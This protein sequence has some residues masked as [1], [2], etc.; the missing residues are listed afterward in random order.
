[1]RP[2]GVAGQPPASQ[3]GAKGPQAAISKADIFKGKPEEAEPF[4][5]HQH[6]VTQRARRQLYVYPP[7]RPGPAVAVFNDTANYFWPEGND[8]KEISNSS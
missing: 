5:P 6:D 7:T 8:A 3:R 4:R 2:K 1:V